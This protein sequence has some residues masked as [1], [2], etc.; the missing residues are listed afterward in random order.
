MRLLEDELTASDASIH[1]SR[2]VHCASSGGFPCAPGDGHDVETIFPTDDLLT[3]RYRI[4]RCLA[5]GG[6]GAVYEAR[7]VTC[8]L[9]CAIKILQPQYWSCPR[10]IERFRKESKVMAALANDYVVPVID[11]GTHLGLP[12][13]VME[14]LRGR[15]LGEVLRNEGPLEPR[16]AVKL[17]LD[18]CRG[19]S[20]IH[21]AGMVHRDIKP[22][23]IF[24]QRDRAGRE[25]I[26]ILDFGVAKLR[27]ATGGTGEGTLL[28]TIAY[29]APEQV[30]SS[31]DV[32]ARADIYSLGAVLYEALSGTRVHQGRAAN[33]LFSVLGDDPVPLYRRRPD[34]PRE[35]SDV[36]M[37][38]LARTPN[39]RYASVEQLAASLR[40]FSSAGNEPC[41]RRQ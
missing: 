27:D 21:A 26:K 14:L 32:D 34:L 30:L 10:T 25:S 16:R 1:G 19:L 22:S 11:T 15:D 2:I 7:D 12:F 4:H 37:R 28:G 29:I 36:V 31:R 24:I 33:L 35:L 39:E 23:N 17:A 9:P 40:P 20:A 3:E 41:F 5:R 6:M 8:G 18:V 13:F 38:A